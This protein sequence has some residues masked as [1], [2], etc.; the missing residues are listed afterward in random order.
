M[1]LETQMPASMQ[2][3]IEILGIPLFFFFCIFHWRDKSK[4]PHIPFTDLVAVMAIADV[5][6]AF[7]SSRLTKIAELAHFEVA[8]PQWYTFAVLSILGFFMCR[9]SVLSCEKRIAPISVY[10]MD[11]GWKRTSRLGGIAAIKD[12]PNWYTFCAWWTISVSLVAA[13]ISLHFVIAGYGC[14]WWPLPGLPLKS[15]PVASVVIA[16]LTSAVV[17]A[18]STVLL[19]ML[20][21][22]QFDADPL[23]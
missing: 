21:Y 17:T 13:Y 9:F 16:M 3:F 15:W 22:Y 4:V 6:L 20:R 14:L 7:D 8:E 18:L 23:D 19:T 11:V 2:A 5:A 1:L 12:N 10:H